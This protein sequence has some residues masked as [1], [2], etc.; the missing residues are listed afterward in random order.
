[1][2]GMTIKSLIEMEKLPITWRIPKT[3]TPFCLE[4]RHPHS[5][6]WTK[7]ITARADLKEYVTLDALFADI[8]RVTPTA[9]VYFGIG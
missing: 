5:A 9:A 2:D 1:M 3:N 7:V 8:K 4:F 6:E